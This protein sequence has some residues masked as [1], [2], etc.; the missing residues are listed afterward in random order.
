MQEPFMVC[1][2]CCT[3]L[4][5]KQ[6]PSLATFNGYFYPEIPKDL[7]D[8]CRLSERLISPRIPFMQIRH[9]R[10]FA[11][12]R[13]LIGQI[14]NV[15]VDVN[16]MVMALPRHLDDDFTFNVCLKRKLLHKSSYM[17]GCISKTNIK[18]WL[19]ELVKTPLY[20]K[21][22]IVI[23]DSFFHTNSSDD[24]EDDGTL[25]YTHLLASS[26]HNVDINIRHTI[27]QVPKCNESRM[28]SEE[29]LSKMQE[30]LFW[31][32]EMILYMAPGQHTQ[33]FALSFDA[34]AEE[35]SFPMIYFGQPRE[36]KVRATAY[37]M[38]TSEIRRRDRRGVKSNHI[39]YMAAK[40]MRYRVID[41]LNVMFRANTSNV[42]NITRSDI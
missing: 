9:I 17:A 21:H 12:S 28:T 5:R 14:V 4:R 8:L 39:L 2:N 1:F 42:H 38:A 40:I 10:Y 33:P 41:S 7:P 32:E 24:E 27:E 37:S 16:N 3:F 23:H 30:T 26:Y 11:G 15:P 25:R 31:G 35:L 6:I 36:F 22:K 29:I 18:I 20:R 13:R 19:K 34:D